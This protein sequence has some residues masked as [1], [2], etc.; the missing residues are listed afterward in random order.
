MRSD[1]INPFIGLQSRT[2][3]RDTYD[4]SPND[5]YGGG[6]YRDSGGNWI[7]SNLGLELNPAAGISFDI[8]LAFPIYNHVNGR[9]ISESF[10]W[11]VA[12]SFGGL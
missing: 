10:I 12:T 8:E 11:R 3:A 4:G 6:A 1:Y 7:Y 5:S 2:S 9:Q